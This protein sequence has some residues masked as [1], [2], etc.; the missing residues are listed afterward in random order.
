M[1]VILPSSAS[2]G[3]EKSK[4]ESTFPTLIF[5]RPSDVML[6]VSSLTM[7]L[8]IFE[9]ALDGTQSIRGDNLPFSI[10]PRALQTRILMSLMRVETLERSSGSSTTPWAEAER[11]S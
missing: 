9:L 10:E 4:E 11:T 2:A 5:L 7:T 8:E 1:T 6:D 3:S